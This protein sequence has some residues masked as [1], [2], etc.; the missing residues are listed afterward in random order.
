MIKPRKLYKTTDLYNGDKWYNDNIAEMKKQAKDYLDECEGDC[1]LI[2]RVL[3][4]ETGKYRR[5]TDGEVK[6]AKLPR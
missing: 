4:Y 1:I 3:N 6:E 5:M 2:Y